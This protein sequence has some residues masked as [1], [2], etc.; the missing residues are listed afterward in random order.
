MHSL[1]GDWEGRARNTLECSCNTR[2]IQTHRASCW[3]CAWNKITVRPRKGGNLSRLRKKTG[4][5]SCPC[6]LEL[7]S[8]NPS[9]KPRIQPGPQFWP[10]THLIDNVVYSSL[11]HVLSPVVV[12]ASSLR[13]RASLH[14]Q[15]NP[16]PCFQ[17]APL[18]QECNCLCV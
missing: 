9:S 16:I 13:L 7:G 6:P 3:G 12:I 2:H 8:Q 18:L 14:R 4:R 5:R 1:R 17:H 15:Y 11:C 10:L